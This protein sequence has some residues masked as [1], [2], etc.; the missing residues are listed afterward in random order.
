MAQAFSGQDEDGPAGGAD[1]VE[2]VLG[3]VPHDVAQPGLRSA[4]LGTNGVNGYTTC[5]NAPD[6][7]TGLGDS[8]PPACP[9]GQ[10]VQ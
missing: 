2:Q 8:G 10:T 6:A 9:D 5:M 4:H 7:Q 3:K 1:G